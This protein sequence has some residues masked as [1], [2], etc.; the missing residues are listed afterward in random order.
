MYKRA[1]LY[2]LYITVYPL[3]FNSRKTVSCPTKTL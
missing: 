2:K 3:H 1:V